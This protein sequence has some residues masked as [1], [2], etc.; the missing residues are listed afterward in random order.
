MQPVPYSLCL[1]MLAISVLCT[2]GVKRALKPRSPCYRRVLLLGGFLL[3]G[4]LA[5]F[6]SWRIYDYDRGWRV[7]GFP[8]AAGFLKRIVLDGNVTWHEYINMPPPL[9]IIGNILFWL[10]APSLP[11]SAFV[12]FSS[13]RKKAKRVSPKTENM[14]GH[15]ILGKPP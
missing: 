13:H 12:W 7:V 9:I 2:F 4:V 11:L 6:F 15:F 5:I 1:V 8:M 3:G 14:S 10:F